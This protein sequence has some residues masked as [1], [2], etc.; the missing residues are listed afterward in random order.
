MV[1]HEAPTTRYGKQRDRL[2]Y[3]IT[4]NGLRGESRIGLKEYGRRRPHAAARMHTQA[5]HIAVPGF[6]PLQ[7]R[8]S[9]YLRWIRRTNTHPH[10]HA[11]TRVKT[12]ACFSIGRGLPHVVPHAKCSAPQKN[13]HRANGT[14]QTVS[15]P[16]QAAKR[17][18]YRRALLAK[19]GPEMGAPKSICQRCRP[20]HAR[21]GIHCITL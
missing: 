7:P 18:S 2:C 12:L 15:K 19:L 9:A 17:S 5:P 13:A 20:V 21:S 14:L 10:K 16:M 4:A 11:H 1:H 3:V 6:A 8:H